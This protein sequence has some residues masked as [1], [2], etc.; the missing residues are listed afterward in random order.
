[1]GK[2]SKPTNTDLQ[3]TLQ[4]PDIHEVWERSYR[5][6][7]SERLYEQV[8][9]WIKKGAGISAGGLVLDAGCGVGQHA[10]R[11]ARRGYQVCAV[12]LAENRVVAARENL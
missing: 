1:M 9:D 8:F 3:D 10:A 6:D 4:R 5:T 2:D 11:L 7:S 12:D